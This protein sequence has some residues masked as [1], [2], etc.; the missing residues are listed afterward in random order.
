MTIINMEEYVKEMVYVVLGINGDG[1]DCVLAVFKTS[2]DALNFC[3]KHPNKDDYADLWI[4]RHE[5]M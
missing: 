1:W 3:S 5:L 2:G 4:E